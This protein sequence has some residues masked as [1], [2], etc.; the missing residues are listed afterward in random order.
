VMGLPDSVFVGGQ[1]YEVF[2]DEN[3]ACEDDRFGECNHRR[4]FITIDM[5]A[6]HARKWET[7]LHEALEAINHQYRIG[8]SHDQTEQLECA[9]YAFTRQNPDFFKE[10]A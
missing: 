10:M 8:L 5:G 1:E 6:H 9:L 2:E 4:L 3:L 7:L